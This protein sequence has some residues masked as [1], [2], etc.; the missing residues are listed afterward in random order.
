MN[1]VYWLGATL[2]R[3]IAKSFLDW[4][5]VGK[6]KLIQEGGCLVAANHESFLDPPLIG[7]SY[8]SSIYYL[9]RKTLFRG[10]TT[11]LYPRWNAIPV[12]Q[13]KPGMGSL[14]KIIKLLQGGERV[15]LFPEGER[16]LTGE[17]NPG[18]P[19]VGLI[20]AKAGVPVQPIRIFG[21]YEALP[22]GSGRLRM[23]PITI[24]VGDPIVFTKEELRERGKDAHQWVSGR[25]MEEIAK[26]ELP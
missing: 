2:F 16:T 9:A 19:G 18:K 4:K 10:P 6:E 12:D 13:E 7:V 3:S 23:L 24:V 11:W 5:V 22:R 1:T 8:D 15:L 26:L 25:I 20:A 21:A 17:L 14:K